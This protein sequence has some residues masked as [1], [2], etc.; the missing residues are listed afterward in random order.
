MFG[1]AAMQYTAPIAA[2][3]PVS[4]VAPAAIFA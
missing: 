2:T 4:I 3:R 1:S